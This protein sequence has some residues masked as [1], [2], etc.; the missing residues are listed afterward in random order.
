MLFVTF[1]DQIITLLFHIV[2]VLRITTVLIVDLTSKKVT[3]SRAL[4]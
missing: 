1:S 3:N 2:I 4:L